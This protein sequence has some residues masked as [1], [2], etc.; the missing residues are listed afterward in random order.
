[1]KTQRNGSMQLFWVRDVNN[2]DVPFK[3]CYKYDD[4]TTEVRTFSSM[5]CITFVAG[6]WDRPVK[7][8]AIRI[9]AR[10]RTWA[11][12]NHL[13]HTAAKL[14]R[15]M[16]TGGDVANFE[17]HDP[18]FTIIRHGNMW[19]EGTPQ[20]RWDYEYYGYPAN[21]AGDT[22]IF[23]DAKTRK[24]DLYLTATTSDEYSPAEVRGT[25]FKDLW[26][27]RNLG[28]ALEDMYIYQRDHVAPPHNL[29]WGEFLNQQDP[30]PPRNARA[31][32]RDQN[33]FEIQAPAGGLPHA[34]G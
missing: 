19:A 7:D 4:R 16:Q 31:V 13:I 12:R 33:N 30:M 9:L 29:C 11:H 23:V 24:L 25:D 26:L 2:L 32:F 8:S 20:A 21:E 6:T 3:L 15:H 27:P 10:N 22:T 14:M 34:G 28:W 18:D 17:E 5:P 1:M